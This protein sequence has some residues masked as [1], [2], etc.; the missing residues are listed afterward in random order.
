M[1]WRFTG[2]D[3]GEPPSDLA[4]GSVLSLD[5]VGRVTLWDIEALQTVKS[6]AAGKETTTSKPRILAPRMAW[7]PHNPETLAV[8]A[9]EGVR[10][11][12]WRTDATVTSDSISQ[13]TR[14]HRYGVC[15]VDYNPNKPHV[16]AT[17]GQDGLLKFWD[18][19]QNSRPLLLTARGGHSH[20]ASRIKYNPFHDQLVLSCGTDGVENLWRASS[21]SS[22]PLLDEDGE[23]NVRVV[24]QEHGD[25]VTALSWG[26]ADAWV[27]M[28]A[29]YDGKVRLNH[30]PSKEKYKILL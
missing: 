18:L 10:L 15:D 8:T 6:A 25:A 3:F 29:A 28:S 13:I 2:S 20:Y 9:G 17:S 22:A 7:D 21:I 19:R 14:A 11:I 5:R 23:Q 4:G 12:D 24:R 1:S 30:V 26:A 27:Y 16:L